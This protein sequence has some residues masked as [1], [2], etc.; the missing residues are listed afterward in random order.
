MRYTQIVLAI[1]SISI[2]SK[3]A[4]TS[5]D[6]KAPY[7][8]A[9]ISDT[10]PY[11]DSSRASGKADSARKA[12]SSRAAWKADSAHVAWF[13]HAATYADSGRA[14]HIADTSK[15][16]G[17]TAYA[18]SSRAS[19]IS[20]SAKA[21]YHY[22][23]VNWLVHGVLGSVSGLIDASGYQSGWFSNKDGYPSAGLFQGELVLGVKGALNAQIVY[24]SS[25]D[26]II[27]IP[28]LEVGSVSTAGAFVVKGGA[29]NQ[30]MKADGSLDTNHYLISS[31]AIAGSRYSVVALN[32][33]PSS[34]A[35]T[36]TTGD[37]RWTDEYI[38][39]CVATNTWKRAALT[40]W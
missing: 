4:L 20:D 26:A 36:G 24:D 7:G 31:G 5:P 17:P 12:D 37:I 33:A 35:D 1:V 10:S 32:P 18:D 25:K 40:T 34:S 11:S 13:A 29:A 3:W 9:Q 8:V 39:I 23:P 28:N 27:A 38:Y 14:S 6:G 22:L 2:A 21:L 30:F 19:L 15:R 16:S